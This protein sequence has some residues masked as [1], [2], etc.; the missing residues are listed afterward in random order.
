MLHL[1]DSNTMFFH[2]LTSLKL[3]GILQFPIDGISYNNWHFFF[4][5]K[6]HDF[7]YYYWWNLKF[8]EILA[9]NYSYLELF[10]VT[11]K[12]EYFTDSWVVIFSASMGDTPYKMFSFCSFW[13]KRG[14][15]D[16]YTKKYF[17]AI[18]LTQ[19]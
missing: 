15:E 2:V 17:L 8:H 5:C 12:M 16:S 11:F 4:L 14:K 3:E 1:V 9:S 10:F 18:I 6:V 13:A 7:I 19:I